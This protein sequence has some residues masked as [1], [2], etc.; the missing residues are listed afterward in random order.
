MS[1]EKESLKTI[2]QPIVRG[3]LMDFIKKHPEAIHKHW[4]ASI[5][6]RIVNDLLSRGSRLRLRAALC[7]ARL[8]ESSD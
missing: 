6:K 3:Q 8:Q 7:E 5:E 2:I 4:L 1:D